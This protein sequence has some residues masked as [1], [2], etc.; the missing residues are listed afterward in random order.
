MGHCVFRACI[1]PCREKPN[2]SFALVVQLNHGVGDGATYYTLL[3]M[4]CSTD[5]ECIRPLN[6]IRDVK[7]LDRIKGHTGKEVC[8][9]MSQRITD[10]TPYVRTY[11]P[12]I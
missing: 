7:F 11:Y 6:A 4:L 5:D 8:E 2:T 10:S 1:L 12:L 3:D 9:Y